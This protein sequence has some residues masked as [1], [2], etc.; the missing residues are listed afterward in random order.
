[1][2]VRY[3]LDGVD[4]ALAYLRDPVLGQRLA[5]A[6]AAVRE[7]VAPQSGQPRRLDDVMGSDI[8][9][10]KLVSCMTLFAAVA[11]RA[12]AADPQPAFAALADDADAI[13]LAAA[14]QGY[15]RCAFTDAQLGRR[16]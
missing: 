12:Q 11:Q 4:E 16:G 14:A 5:V 7:H 13:L 10:L 2:A 6:T 15:E 1:M 8:D 3:G 9:A